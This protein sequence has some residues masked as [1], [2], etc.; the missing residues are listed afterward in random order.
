M[1]PEDLLVEA[2]RCVKCG[3]CLTVCPTY[4]LLASEADSPR[5]RISLIQALAKKE[6]DIDSHAE[7]HL[8]RCLNCRACE[9]ACPSGVKY[10]SL[11]DASRSSIATEHRKKPLLKRLLH[12]LSHNGRLNYW[13]RLYHAIRQSGLLAL[14]KKLP[15][16]RFR[17]LLTMAEQL[18]PTAVDR[19]G[20]YPSTKPTGKKVQLF[21]GCIGSKI[22]D[23]LVQ[24]AI[25]LLCGLGYAIDIPTGTECCGAMHRHNGF[26][27]EAEQQCD[28][29]RTQTAKSSAQYLIT[30]ATACHLELADQQA[31]R[32]PL[33]S[34]SDFLLQ[35]PDREMPELAPM[36]IRAVL[37]RP[38]SSR[39]SSD[40]RIL[41]KIPQ[42]E[43]IELAENELCCGAAG[44]Y[45][46]TQPELSNQLGEMKLTHLKA[47]GAKI[48]I[49]TSTGCAM[50]FRQQI[51]Q[52]G[53]SIEVRHP[54][55][56]IYKQW[57]TAGTGN[58]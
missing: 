15:A 28:T 42:L 55:E 10:G 46:L 50:Q 39:D 56:L 44:S 16:P 53:L 26:I 47:S 51:R 24:N 5:G 27:E 1:T 21:T 43:L 12:Q 8:D 29:I 7:Q 41:N 36:P 45:I 32:L 13:I 37:H 40:W 25:Q 38:C 6:I 23:N 17:Q 20:F 54:I 18:P 35:L 4:R 30:L 58:K 11:L 31:S 48:L 19:T 33:V 22:D 34:I 3:L 9:S 57:A 14:A 49:T 52:A 2:D